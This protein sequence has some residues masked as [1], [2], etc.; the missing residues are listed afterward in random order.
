MTPVRRQF[1][2]GPYGQIHVR[3]CG[4]VSA[5][6][7]PIVFLH[8]FPQSGRNYETLLPYVGHDRLAVA[9]DFPGHGESAV[10]PEPILAD[11]YASSIWTAID[12]LGLFE[13]HAA[14]DLFGIHAGAKLAVALAHQRPQSVHRIMLCAAAVFHKEE[15]E[16][17]QALY[18]PVALDEAGTRFTFLWDLLLKNRAEGVTLDM[19]AIGLAEML[20]AGEA[21]EW[22]HHAV[23]DY[24]AVFPDH[25]KALEHEIALLNPG[26]DLREY[27]PRSA[28]YL[29]NGQLFERPE[30]THGFMDLSA[31]PFAKQ[32]TC[33]MDGGLPALNAYKC[34]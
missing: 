10:P 19:A 17:M 23:F 27:T 2:D 20:R 30:W 6:N 29:Q 25:L 22:G 1:V 9:P 26:D 5:K 15:L 16:K 13:T 11:D 14:I 21:Y 31:E 12:A 8:M 33:F 24:N 4:P 32:I 34:E 3:T 7:R 18:K 28:A